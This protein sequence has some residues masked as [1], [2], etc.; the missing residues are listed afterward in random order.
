MCWWIP[1]K[2]IHNI[3]FI[4]T[5]GD[6]SSIGNESMEFRIWIWNSGLTLIGLIWAFMNRQWTELIWMAHLKLVGRHFIQFQ[7]HLNSNDVKQFSV[8]LRVCVRACVSV[9]QLIRI[10]LSEFSIDSNQFS[11]ANKWRG[12]RTPESKSLAPLSIVWIIGADKA[13]MGQSFTDQSIHHAMP[14]P[15]GKFFFLCK[16]TTVMWTA[17]YSQ[18]IWITSIHNQ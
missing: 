1:P 18:R 15:A 16:F 10:S 6:R 8:D 12:N 3:G 2:R 4:I 14:R 7:W 17:L 5:N 13:A 11:N 9:C